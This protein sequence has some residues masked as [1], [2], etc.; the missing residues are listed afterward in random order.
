M[1]VQGTI[2]DL[3]V[4]FEGERDFFFVRP[5]TWDTVPPHATIE[6]KRLYAGSIAWVKFGGQAG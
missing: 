4:P 3:T 6:D 5:S 2:V 1:P